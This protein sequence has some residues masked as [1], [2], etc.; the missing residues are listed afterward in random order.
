MAAGK[1]FKLKI[2][3]TAVGRVFPACAVGQVI[4]F[5]LVAR[6]AEILPIE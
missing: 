1:Y 5:A 6:R 4:A 2:V 3:M